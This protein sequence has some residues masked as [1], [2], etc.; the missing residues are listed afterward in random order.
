M[1]GKVYNTKT[2][3]YMIGKEPMTDNTRKRNILFVCTHNSARSQMAEGLMNHYFSGNYRA[4]SAG[5]EATLVKPW[6]I[7]ALALDGIDISHHYSK[8]IDEFKGETFDVVVT[9]CDNARE[10]CPFF[11]GA[12]TN[13]HMSFEDPSL[14]QGGEEE[15]VNAFA[16]SR[17]Q[18]KAWM[19]DTFKMDPEE[20]ETP[21]P[22]LL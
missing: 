3:Y 20:V 1:D 8:T 22:V 7:K 4:Y 17:D 18:I 19:D 13:I 11:P 14:V 21:G 15:K 5:T 16:R 10:N 9:V 12:Q 2:V 6:A